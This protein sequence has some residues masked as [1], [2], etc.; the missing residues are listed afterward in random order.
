MADPKIKVEIEADIK[1][2]QAGVNQAEKELSAIGLAADIVSEKI[3]DVGS[4]FSV[5]GGKLSTFAN[6]ADKVEN[7]LKDIGNATELA[8][9][10]IADFGNKVQATAPKIDK[11]TK[12]TSNFNAVGTDFARIL[13]DAPFGIIG[14]SN[15]I[16]Q[17]ASSFGSARA[18]GESIPNILKGIFS[19]GNLLTI[20][21][22][23]LTSAFVVL[24]QQGF[25]RSQ[26]AAESLGEALDEYRKKL[27]GVTRASIEG[28]ANSQKEIQNFNLL[29]AQ[30]ENTNIPLNARLEAVRDLKKEY[31]EYLNGLTNEQILTGKVGG[32]YDELTKSITATAKARA[33]SDQIA[34]NSL[35][36]LTLE[37]QAQE[38][39]NTLLQKQTQLAPLLAAQANQAAK[40]RGEFTGLDLQILD[41]QKEIRDLQLEQVEN[42]ENAN[43]L[44]TESEKLESKITE[45][46][47]N[48]AKFTNEQNNQLKQNILTLEQYTKKWSDNE[49]AILRNLKLQRQLEITP[50]TQL[51]ISFG[52]LTGK[53]GDTAF[54]DPILAIQEKIEKDLANFKL[55]DI[56]APEFDQAS[57]NLFFDRIEEFKQSASEI[58]ESGIEQSIGNFAFAIGE[59]LANGGDVFK[60]LGGA[61]LGGVAMVLDQL[62]Q[63][64]IAAGVGMIAIKNAFKNPA[65]AIA[66]GVGLIAL[67]GFIKSKVGKATSSIGGGGGGSFST[68][69]V[70]GG[71]TFSGQGATGLQFDRSLQ[72]A[73]EF[74]VKGQDLV[75]VFNEASSK[76][77]RG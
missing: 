27:D 12:A 44:K 67:A 56:K 54:A 40:S 19:G 11:A 7:Q 45:Q 28:Q 30:A 14:V 37:Q 66:A 55:P 58:L 52:L 23:A 13:Q 18:K 49:D 41:L 8:E 15:N 33:F 59:A 2:L 1:G 9:N 36:L 22:S 34:K 71:T 26:K 74:R 68:S 31:P 50:A 51:E 64:A 29:R 72:L 10:Q 65:T 5:A 60:K 24:E 62:G 25:F 61:I 42:I 75:Y 3:E 16:T 20:G 4:E 77:Q 21:I 35:D 76:N 47:V 39:V 43:K 46:I 73:G 57:S 38:R 63:A 32:A 17:L 70:S 53:E 69:G 6:T 48:G